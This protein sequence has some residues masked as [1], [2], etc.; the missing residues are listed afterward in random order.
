MVTRGK[1]QFQ[2][3]GHPSIGFYGL[4]AVLLAA[5]GWGIYAYYREFTEGMTQTGLRDVGTMGGATWGL[6]VAFIIYFVG[7]SFAGITTAALVRMLNL[8]QLRPI[9]RIAEL[10]TIIALI[11]A[12]CSVLVDLGQPLRGIVNLFRYARPQSPFFG[13]FSLVISG[14]LFASL[15]YF[16]LDGRRDAALLARYPSRLRWFYRLWAAGYRDTPAERR[17][18][19][20]ASFWLAI[21]ILPLLVTAHST[22]GFVFG[23]QS[24]RPGWFSALQAPG[25]VVMA[26]ISGLGLLAVIAAVIRVT[27][28]A[29]KQVITEDV[30]RYLGIF[31][32]GLILTYLYFTVAEL[33]TVMYAGP[34]HDVE[35]TW[36]LL[37]GEYAWL[38][39]GSVGGLVISLILLAGS[40][41][42]LRRHIIGSAVV[43]GLLVNLAAIG[44]RFLIVVPSQTVGPLLPYGTGHYAPTWVEYSIVLGLFALGTLMFALFSRIFPLIELAE[45]VE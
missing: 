10:L 32:A 12:A 36:A 5:F 3:I 8:R 38:F 37:A 4:V 16:Y 39:W 15:V 23:I 40:I 2:V 30:F 7:V 31:L 17:R 41:F 20:I 18:H 24:G 6:Y 19:Q 33:L 27:S 29:G 25:F 11:L 34:R 9:S 43:S 13:T 42:L 45:E 14:Y 26:G 44:K 28:G 22:L 1:E 35:T 21:A